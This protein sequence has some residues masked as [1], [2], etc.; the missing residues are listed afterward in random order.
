MTLP[1]LNAVVWTAMAFA[2]L[3]DHRRAWELL[4]M[5]NPVNHALSPEAIA[6]YKVEPYVVAADIYALSPHTGRGGWTWYTGS[7]GWLYRLGLEAILG[8]N[9]Q[10]DS[11]S[12]RP[13]VPKEWNSFSITYRFGEASYRIRV[14]N[15]EGVNQGVQEVTLDGETLPDGVIPLKSEKANHEVS[16]RLGRKAN[17]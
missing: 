15:P 2:A 5:I 1:K 17:D 6:V 9:R 8:L 13:C 12:V 16:I 11:L 3:G 10:G 7:S 14:E 4:S